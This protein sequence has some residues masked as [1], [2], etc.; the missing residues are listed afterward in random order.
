MLCVC[1]SVVCVCLLV[2]VCIGCCMCG[3]C[4]CVSCVFGVC[5]ASVVCVSCVCVAC[6]TVNVCGKVLCGVDGVCT[7]AWCIQVRR[8]IRG[9]GNV[10]FSTYS[11][12]KNGILSNFTWKDPR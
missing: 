4:L 3:F 2:Y 12:T 1:R 7:V 5:C 6:C 9:I 11:Q 10:L 8:M